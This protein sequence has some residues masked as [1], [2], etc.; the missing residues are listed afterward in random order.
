MD[1]DVMRKLYLALTGVFNN[2]INFFAN[3]GKELG[4]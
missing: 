1:W 3:I 4:W 2:I